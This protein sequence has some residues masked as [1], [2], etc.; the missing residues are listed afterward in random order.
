MLCFLPYAPQGPA[1]SGCCAAGRENLVADELRG[2]G[3]RA[4]IRSQGGGLAPDPLALL[5]AFC[6]AG[7]SKMG[8]APQAKKIWWPV[9]DERR[10][11]LRGR[12]SRTPSGLGTE[13]PI[14]FLPFAPQVSPKSGC[15]AAAAPAPL[16]CF[17]P[18]APQAS[19]KRVLRRRPRKF[20]GLRVAPAFCAAG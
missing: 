5:S 2:R 16:L 17:L 15:C 1:Q 19:P 3:S 10:G 9:A 18:S 20:G 12:E 13:S 8:A 7:Q 6:A 11:Q 14:R 4:P